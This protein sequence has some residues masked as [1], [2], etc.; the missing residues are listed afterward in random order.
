MV[1]GMGSTFEERLASDRFSVARR[2]GAGG[3]G[4]VYEARDRERGQRV[5]LKT[6]RQMDATALYW[7]KRE[8]RALADVLHPNL[9]R[10]HELVADG[11]LWFFSMELVDGVDFLEYVRPGLYEDWATLSRVRTSRSTAPGPLTRPVDWAPVDEGRSAGDPG[12][13]L[14]EALLD[15][16]RLRRALR[17][18]AEGVHAIHGAGRLHRDLK[19]SNVLVTAEGRVVILDFG[20]MVEAR[21][22]RPFVDPEGNI[23]GTVSY[24]SPEQAGGL[25][26]TPASDWYTVG[27]MLFEAL[28][29]RP[30]FV[31]QKMAVLGAKQFAAPQAPSELARGVPGDLEQLC[32]EL[33][34]TEPERRP[35]GEVILR[36]LG[37]SSPARARL[38]SRAGSF[39]GRAGQLRRLHEAFAVARGGR[40]VVAGV[41]GVPG[42]GKTATA[43]AFL[44]AVGRSG[45]DALVLRGR[46]FE[47]ETVPFKA[48]DGLVDALA[49]ELRGR[50]R[51]ELAPL[52]PDGIGALARLF[53][54]LER[55]EA[56]AAAVRGGAEI[57]DAA[58]LRRVAFEALRRLLG[59]LAA[60]R[61]LVLFVDDLQWGDMDSAALLRELLR[62][63]APPP[64]L[65]IVAYR[66]ADADSSPC[67]AEVLPWLAG[68]GCAAELREVP[69]GAL[70]AEEGRALAATLIEDAGDA[71]RHV[72]REAGGDPFFIVELARYRTERDALERAGSPPGTSR[73][74]ATS[75]R[76]VLDWR[77]SRLPAPA[78]RL[79]EVVAVAGR[80]VERSVA[81]GASGLGPA[82]HEALDELV[83]AHLV[84]SRSAGVT[85]SRRV[86]KR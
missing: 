61:P 41:H 79:L 55:V 84:R 64:L 34:R 12:S 76:E 2:L 74:G 43:L 47:R 51:D 58:Q 49:R 24:M 20:L 80:P 29:G 77:F 30:P 15:E 31:G 7:F 69:V 9:I 26:L 48:F 53:P 71:A 18:L 81:R 65:L 62:P 70:T 38:G 40:A 4:V 8:F 86:W 5:A 56:V 68:P 36:R 37:V 73:P 60:R 11:D 83:A 13:G 85:R 1:N 22:E 21:P 33:L 57:P 19:P 72:A 42:I 82:E 35:V 59:A 67:L 66:S 54:V 63:P 16:G 23:S 25:P 44:D 27:V 28:T 14:P 6:L 75:V 39:V 52:L 17:Q 45:P 10:L 50:S 78:R 3:M 46:C 32:V